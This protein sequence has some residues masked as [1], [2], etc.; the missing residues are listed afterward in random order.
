MA[1]KQETS[2]SPT[3]AEIQAMYICNRND[4]AYVIQPIQYTKKY[5]V[6]KF[7]ISNRFILELAGL[8]FLIADIVGVSMIDGA[9][10]FQVRGEDDRIPEGEDYQPC[11]VECTKV[12]SRLV[13]VNT[14]NPTGQGM[15]HETGK[16]ASR[17]R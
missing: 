3:E 2:Y 15:T 13:P 1:K 6:V 7:Q 4:L 16:E 11:F 9:L 17:G 10:E 5:K 12:I 8:D 14:P